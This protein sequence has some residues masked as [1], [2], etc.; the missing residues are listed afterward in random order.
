MSKRVII[1]E[2][3]YN[4]VFLNEEKIPNKPHAGEIQQFLK[5]KGLYTGKVDSNFKDESAKAFAQYYYGINTDIDTVHKLWKKLKSEGKNVGSTTGFGP[6]MV[7]VLYDIIKYKENPSEM[8]SNLYSD[9]VTN[10]KNYSKKGVEY[11]KKGATFLD[12]NV[13][14]YLHKKYIKNQKEGNEFREWVHS[15]KSRLDVVNEKLKELGYSEKFSKKG[16]FNND[17]FLV[18]WDL[19]G[20]SFIYDTKKEWMSDERFYDKKFDEVSKDLDNTL[21]EKINN[22]K[23]TYK[24]SKVYKNYVNSLNNWDKVHKDFG[25]GSTKNFNLDDS[26]ITQL[27]DVIVTTCINPSWVLMKKY[28]SEVKLRLSLGDIEMKD[29]GLE[30]FGLALYGQQSDALNILDKDFGLRG[31]TDWD[32]LDKYV[33]SAY[34]KYGKNFTKPKKPDYPTPEGDFPGSYSTI[35]TPSS[36]ALRSYKS[37]SMT[38]DSELQ[39]NRYWKVVGPLLGV[40]QKELILV[41]NNYSKILDFI[42]NH[43]KMIIGQSVDELIRVG[44]RSG[45]SKV[46]QGMSTMGEQFTPMLP[47]LP[48]TSHYGE[49]INVYYNMR[50]ACSGFGGAFLYFNPEDSIV[51]NKYVCCVNNVK[52]KTKTI[53]AGVGNMS[54]LDVKGKKFPIK[55][56][57]DDD[58]KSEN[59]QPWSE[60][61]EDKAKD[62]ASDWH[63]LADIVS[64]VSSFFGPLGI[65]VGAGIDLLSGLGYFIEGDEG[66][67]LNG[68][69][70]L[71]GVIPGIGETMKLFKGGPKVARTLKE[72]G[73]AVKGLDSI[74]AAI[75]IKKIT[76]SLD[77][78]TKKQI[79]NI[80]KGFKK[81]EGKEEYIL[82][83]IKNFTKEISDLS[84][85]ENELL[86]KVS[87]ELSP[88]DFVIQYKKSGNLKT[89]LSKL[90]VKDVV[91]V[92][93]TIQIGLF[94]GMYLGGESIGRGLANINK[95]YGWDPFGLF[96]SDGEEKKSDENYIDWGLIEK[97]NNIKQSIESSDIGID[98]SKFGDSGE[99]YME[100]IEET[101]KLIGEYQSKI[102]VLQKSFDDTDEI[103]KLLDEIKHYPYTL[104]STGINDLI[105]NTNKEILTFVESL[106]M[107][108]DK[109]KLIKELET[110]IKIINSIDIPK[111]NN[112]QIQ[113]ELIDKKERTTQ[114]ADDLINAVKALMQNNDNTN[115]DN[116]DLKEEINRIKKL[117]T[118]ERLYGNLVNEACDDVDDA[119]GFLEKKGYMVKTTTEH[120]LCIGIGTPLGKVYKSLKTG[121][122]GFK[123]FKVNVKNYGD[124]CGLTF[125]NNDNNGRFYILSLFSDMDDV[126]SGLFN[127]FYKMHSDTTKDT[128]PTL[129]MMG[130]K[131]IPSG[132][133]NI[134]TATPLQINMGLKYIKVEGK[135]NYDIN[136]KKVTLKEAGVTGLF[137]KN[138]KGIK[139]KFGRVDLSG[140]LNNETGGSLEMFSIDGTSC[141]NTG[142]FVDEKLGWDL[143]TEKDVEIILDKIK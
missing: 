11:L 92:S 111:K 122:S 28:I 65:L 107:T 128:C 131:L 117:F 7:Q 40:D 83:N 138:V 86:S 4:R 130:A 58:C 2:S 143:S 39:K 84:K 31:M 91:N 68:S 135:W 112:Q 30:S 114:E 129:T 115:D 49:T 23:T 55:V 72:I 1:T 12:K 3:Q 137:D 20:T 76:K 34:S 14:N 10:V 80:L 97:D 102:K 78:T 100:K 17:Y 90:K 64:I 13:D 62:C 108:K 73:S 26:N 71:L 15:K 37:Q 132:D 93:S 123:N 19:G 57:F 134:G 21:K 59:I 118:N 116:M 119:I 85:W 51:K 79:D 45:T 63:C 81:L 126:N 124:Q 69:L 113:L 104:D 42:D 46:Y 54:A 36:S 41:R 9:L 88:E 101:S 95:K 48:N 125:K 43:N 94:G 22:Y 35:K 106:D 38:V 47:I 56:K 33:E 142:E 99:F 66:A 67:N 70:T 5:D 32:E 6:K 77:S 110:F 136:T 16:D 89:M 74:E 109:T 139:R 87:K 75:A 96:D 52:G 121:Y 60:W 133:F 98:L 8:L 105:K 103:F 44:K 25:W 24:N 61:L 29:D 120:D 140:T 127:M 50:D 53:Y 141:L 82:S 27:N 18:A